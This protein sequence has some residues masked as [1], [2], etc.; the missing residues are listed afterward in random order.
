MDNQVVG[1]QGGWILILVSLFLGQCTNPARQDPQVEHDIHE[2]V[3]TYFNTALIRSAKQRL[4]EEHL[5]WL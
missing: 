5:V 4:P 1:R 3:I 2:D